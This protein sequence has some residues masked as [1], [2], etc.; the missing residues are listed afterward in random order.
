MRVYLRIVS[1]NKII[2]STSFL[3]LIGFFIM[4]AMASDRFVDHSDGT[5]TDNRTGLMWATKDNGSSINW[6]NALSY[7]QKYS[8]GGYIDWR[9]PTLF[10]LAGLYDP[11]EKNKWGYHVTKLINTSAASCWASDIRGYK[12]ARF[13]F[14]YG[15][16]YWLRQSYSGPTGSCQYGVVIN[17][18]Y[19]LHV[20]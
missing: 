1:L 16:V 13:N 4:P 5:V 3:V 6:Q 20:S 8:G 19:A 10:E 7:C 18:D 15:E 17:L 12:A 14:T 2:V 11:K 9:M